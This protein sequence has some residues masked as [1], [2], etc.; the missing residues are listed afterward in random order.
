[1][2]ATMLSQSARKMPN[3]ATP[4]STISGGDCLM[5]H[6]SSQ[7]VRGDHAH[8]RHAQGMAPTQLSATHNSTRASSASGSKLG[9][10]NGNQCTHTWMPVPRGNKKAASSSATTPVCANRASRQRNSRSICTLRS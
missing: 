7:I 2:K 6:L 9:A 4:A 10:Q 8:G 3:E 1:M 5:Q